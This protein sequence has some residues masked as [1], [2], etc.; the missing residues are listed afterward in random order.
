MNYYTIPYS[1]DLSTSIS[2]F[3]VSL[4]IT[5]L[6]YCVFPLIYAKSR[7]NPIQK[8]KYTRL[9]YGIN[10]L[11]MLLFAV[12]NGSSSGAPYFLWTWVFSKSGLKTLERRGLLEEVRNNRTVDDSCQMSTT[13][14]TAYSLSTGQKICFC[15]K[16]GASLKGSD[17]FCSNCGTEVIAVTE[18]G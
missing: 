9:C 8:K 3:V 16:C 13:K 6:A 12:I 14:T 7:K 18:G 5:V 17:H 4:G 2:L 15:R 11:V 10:F 1:Q